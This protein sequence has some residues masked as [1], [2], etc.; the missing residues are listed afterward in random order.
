MAGAGAARFLGPKIAQFLSSKGLGKVVDASQVTSKVPINTIKQLPRVVQQNLTK[1]RTQNIT[2]QAK[3][4]A[5]AATKAKNIKAGAAKRKGIAPPK[6]TQT[7]LEDPSTLIGR[8]R[9]TRRQVKEAQKPKRTKSSVSVK[10]PLSLDDTMKIYRESE[11]KLAGA[12]QARGATP[13]TS[14]SQK[15]MRL[16]RKGETVKRKKGGRIG[17]PKGVG[18]AKRGYGKAMKRGK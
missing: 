2:Q 18:V 6:K 9:K 1:T 4:A 10:K 3:D 14:S 17:K 11:K 15:G 12:K 8:T 13:T 5:A 16:P 7:E